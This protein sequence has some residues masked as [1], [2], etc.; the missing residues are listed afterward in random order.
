MRSS[1]R[2]M[3]LVGLLFI[4]GSVAVYWLNKHSGVDPAISIFD[5]SELLTPAPNFS[6]ITD[7]AERK[8]EFFSFLRPGVAFENHRILQERQQLARLF[9]RWQS[10]K[11]NQ[12][13]KLWA[14]EIGDRYRLPLADGYL[15]T[16]VWFDEM[17]KRVD[18]LPE[19]LVMIQAANESAWGTSRF[20]IEAN[21]FFGQWCYSKGCG[22]VPLARGAGMTHEVAKF[23]TVQGSIYGY[24]MNVNRNAAYRELRE[25]RYQQRKAGADLLTIE[26]G[27]LLSQGLLR[28]SERGADYVQELQAMI[29]HNQSYLSNQMVED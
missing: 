5:G 22:I 16:Q 29:R 27:L 18:L 1:Y 11:L 3:L 25:I 19:S 7:V 2:R 12:R 14:N 13:D 26:S 23:A 20:A 10:G 15:I 8:H 21:N 4:I 9:E 24:F 17:D 6:K 28:Y